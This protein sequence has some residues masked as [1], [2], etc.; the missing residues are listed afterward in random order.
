MSVVNKKTDIYIDLAVF[1]ATVTMAFC[2]KW[3]ADDLVWSLWISSLTLGYSFIFV[4]ITS[5]MFRGDPGFVDTPKK[6]G[7]KSSKRR[8]LLV[9][10]MN[11][12]VLLPLFGFFGLSKITF[13]VT[14]LIAFSII[15]TIAGILQEQP[16]WGFLPSL[17][18]PVVRTIIM[19]PSC[20]F[21]L[22]FFSVHFL[23]FHFIHSIFL[24]GFFPIID[25]NPFGKNFE[26]TFAFF[27]TILISAFKKYWPFILASA[28]SQRNEYA[29]A[30]GSAG[31]SML[32]KPYKNVVKMHLMI[33]VFAGLS[34]A[35]LHNVALYP[36]LIVY[37]LPIK[38]M[39]NAFRKTGN[40]KPA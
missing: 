12:F 1:A 34:A 15:F 33:F 22:A 8:I 18:N 38:S 29:V 20:F 28:L 17:S 10:P 36:V 4:S 3:S 32:F 26:Q 39:V 40:Q 5:A 7:I 21:M 11:I 30:L 27:G 24:N 19:L 23:G 9:M 35:G 31:P 14:L 2:F 6:Y 25:S 16:R 37:F 13:W